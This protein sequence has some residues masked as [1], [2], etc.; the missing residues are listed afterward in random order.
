[1]VLSL[2]GLGQMS[3]QLPCGWA[4]SSTDERGAHS[5]SGECWR[6]VVQVAAE[7]LEGPRFSSGI[8]VP[9]YIQ[10]DDVNGTTSEQH[11]GWTLGGDDEL[12]RSE[13]YP[14]YSKLNQL[15]AERSFAAFVEERCQRFYASS[16]G[17]HRE[18]LPIKMVSNHRG[19]AARRDRATIFL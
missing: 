15:L 7:P 8:S 14:F 5:P 12:P 18:L 11:S 6:P 10:K 17:C 13:G 4:I 16:Q 9:R 1:L 3:Q 19:L 2:T